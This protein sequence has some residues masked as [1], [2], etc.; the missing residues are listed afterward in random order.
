VAAGFFSRTAFTLQAQSLTPA[1]ADIQYYELFKGQMFTQS[2]TS[3]PIPAASAP[4]AFQVFVDPLGYPSYYL[5]LV[6]GPVIHSPAA[7]QHALTL[8]SQS[9]GGVFA[10]NFVHWHPIEG[11]IRA[12]SP[13][14]PRGIERPTADRL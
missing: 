14:S 10:T 8:N 3:S 2:G 9:I 13:R 1:G 11:K 6:L 12:C 7:G 4:Y 5:P